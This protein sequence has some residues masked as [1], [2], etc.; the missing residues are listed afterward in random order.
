[1]RERCQSPSPK[2]RGPWQLRIGPHS[3][4]TGADFFERLQHSRPSFS[5]G[6]RLRMTAGVKQIR[7]ARALSLVAFAVSALAT[8]IMV[9]WTVRS[10]AHRI[11]DYGE[12]CVL[13]AASRLRNGYVLYIDP[14]LGAYEYGSVPSR[15]FVP[16]TPIYPALLSLLP[17]SL[18]VSGARIL[19]T[20]CTLYAAMRILSHAYAT[21]DAVACASKPFAARTH[22]ILATWTVLL[23]TFGF[24]EFSGWLT[25]AKPEAMALACTIEGFLRTLRLGRGSVFSSILFATGFFLK[26]SF[27]G[28]GL[29]CVV[30]SGLLGPARIRA[31][32]AYALTMGL[33]AFALMLASGGQ[34]IRHMRAAL[35]FAFVWERLGDA[36]AHHLPFLAGVLVAGTVCIAASFRRQPWQARV[37]SLALGSSC[38]FACTGLLKIG[39]ASNYCIEPMFACAAVTAHFGLPW[40]ALRRTLA[41]STLL[42]SS[43]WSAVAAAR[44]SRDD[45]RYWQI[46]PAAVQAVRRLCRTTPD[47]VAVADQPGVEWLISDRVLRHS[48]EFALLGGKEPAHVVAWEGDARLPGITCMVLYDRDDN[49]TT[50]PDGLVPPKVLAVYRERFPLR[51]HI[52]SFTVFTKRP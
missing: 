15:T 47:E 4:S 21:D 41:A 13:F 14:L 49:R 42:F 40:N 38:F 30:A 33:I 1:M 12:A 2:P 3:V 32:A 26:P 10:V 19:G 24:F 34:F 46:E 9:V 6:F 39:S 11:P 36:L 35:G 25:N 16:Y 18:Q 51:T 50:L 52:G 29:G 43:L 31:I 8:G 23:S 48:L 45:Y 17:A 7:L 44:N 27:L 28:L 20:I 5:S 37:S 22:R